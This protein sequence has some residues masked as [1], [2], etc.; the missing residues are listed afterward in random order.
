MT[1]RYR[2]ESRVA[3]TFVGDGGSRSGTFHETLNMAALWSA[4]F[5]L[6]VENNQYAYSTPLVQQMPHS[7][8]FKHADAYDIVGVQVDGNDVE[9][10]YHAVREAVERARQGFGPTL[11]E[12]VTMRM[13]GH[14]I[15]DGAEYVPQGL[16]EEW[17]TKDPLERQRNRLLKAD[18]VTLD[19][20]EAIDREAKAQV[21]AAIRAAE[22]APYPTPATLTEGVWA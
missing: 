10:V 7:D 16:L 13:L 15:H 20:L 11:V 9:A 5:V 1:F 12:A 4:P 19:Q 18:A 2:A 8:I 3:L 14:A 21:Q 22:A 17:A 6:V